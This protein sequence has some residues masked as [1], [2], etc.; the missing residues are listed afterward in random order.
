[1][2][3]CTI[4]YYF[5]SPQGRI[6]LLERNVKF[7]AVPFVGSQ[8]SLKDEFLFVEHIHFCEDSQPILFVPNQSLKSDSEIDQAIEQKVVCGWRVESDTRRKIT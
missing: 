2:I 1:M 4:R 8:L 5:E 3:E 7:P 6:V